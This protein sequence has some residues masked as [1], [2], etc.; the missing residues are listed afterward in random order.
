MLPTKIVLFSNV[1]GNYKWLPNY[2]FLVSTKNYVEPF[3]PKKKKSPHTNAC[4][5]NKNYGKNCKCRIYERAEHNNSI[6]LK[7]YV[8]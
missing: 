5:A 3:F 7:K 6:P 8:H 1:Q 2:F 4:F